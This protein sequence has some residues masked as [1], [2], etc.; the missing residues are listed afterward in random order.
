MGAE[1]RAARRRLLMLT[2]QTAPLPGCGA[3]CMAEPCVRRQEKPVS[4]AG[5]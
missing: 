4:E 5:L 2:G 3:C 1:K